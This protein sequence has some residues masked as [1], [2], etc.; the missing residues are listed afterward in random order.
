M[1]DNIITMDWQ[2]GCHL[3]TK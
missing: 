2:W 3:L 1:R